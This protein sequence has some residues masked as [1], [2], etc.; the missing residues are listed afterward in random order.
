MQG[1]QE[2]AWHLVD[3]YGLW[4]MLIVAFIESSFFP[5]PPDVLLIVLVGRLPQGA[6]LYAIVCTLGSVLGAILGY[7]IGWLGGRPLLLRLFR[8]DKVAQAEAL[9]GQYGVW[10]VFIAAFTPIPFKVFTISSGVFRLTILG[11]VIA[12]TIGRGL[13][14]FL[15]AY[16]TRFLGEAFLKRFDAISIAVVA[17]LGIIITGVWLFHR[18][19]QRLQFATVSPNPDNDTRHHHTGIAKNGTDVE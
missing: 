7:A 14:F 6:L 11:F 15:V 3:V 16:A 1:L 8:N 5:V 17:F 10:A 13:R 12:S 4:G 19:R 18:R 2:W 9:Y